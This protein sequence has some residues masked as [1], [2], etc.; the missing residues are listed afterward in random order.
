M[1]LI[2]KPNPTTNGTTAD[3]AAASA[4][5][6]TIYSEFNGNIDD[7]NIKPSAG[8]QDS[9]L[10]T[11]SS[12]GKVNTT[13]IT[14]TLTNAAMNIG[15]GANNTIAL[16]ASSQ[17]PAV[18]ASN[19][20]GL[21][22][23]SGTVRQVVNTIASAL[24]TGSNVMALSDSIPQNTDGNQYMT[25]AITPTNASSKLKIEV[26]AFVSCNAVELLQGALFQDS[27][28][29]A[30][31]AGGIV[32]SNTGALNVFAMTHF[33]T[34]G[35]VSSTTFKFR[36]GPSNGTHTVSFNGLNNGRDFGGVCTSSITITE[37]IP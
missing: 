29:N 28:A 34:A 3:G 20:V 21:P 24:A 27:T 11:I 26:I 7:N 15:T 36:L 2:T 32:A 10:A 14:G 12:A 17:L 8:I 13:A 22:Y 1:G 33:M 25:L 5:W 35:T 23:N 16:N 37:I 6:D 19:L 31:A 4:N 30:L 18:S 9:K